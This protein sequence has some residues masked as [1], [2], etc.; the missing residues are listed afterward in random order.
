MINVFGDVYIFIKKDENRVKCSAVV[1]G[2]EMCV[3]QWINV[4][5]FNQQND[6]IKKNMIELLFKDANQKGEMFKINVLNGSL[7]VKKSKKNNE[8]YF[9]LVIND[10]SDIFTIEK[11]EIEQLE[12]YYKKG[13]IIK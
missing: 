10:F 2:D 11:D 6:L 5:K 8:N 7:T 12:Y 4:V 3:S 1:H 13:K 9:A